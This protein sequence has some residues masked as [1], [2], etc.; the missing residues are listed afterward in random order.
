MKTRTHYRHYPEERF[1]PWQFPDFY[2]VHTLLGVFVV[3]MS[4]A[5]HVEHKLATCSDLEWI[6][7]H[8]WQQSTLC[9]LRR[10]NVPGD[11]VVVACN[12]TPVPRMDYRV[13]VPEPGYYRELMNSDSEIYGGSNLGNSGGVPALAEPWHGRPYSLR[14]TL[15]PLSVLFLKRM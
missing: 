3:S 2:Q 9:Y 15:P 13:G 1:K 7:F 10:A 11:F 5:R 12:F 14:L 8:D 4:T 6:D